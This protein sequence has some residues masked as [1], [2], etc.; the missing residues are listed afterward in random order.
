MFLDYG[1]YVPIYVSHAFVHLYPW[2]LCDPPCEKVPPPPPPP[3]RL[4]YNTFRRYLKVNFN[5]YITQ[6][7]LFKKK[8]N[9][10]SKFLSVDDTKRT[11]LLNKLN[12]LHLKNSTPLPFS[13]VSSSND[14]GSDKAKAV[15]SATVSMAVAPGTLAVAA[16]AE[17]TVIAEVAV[18][19]AAVA[20]VTV[21]AVAA[22]ATLAAVAAA[23]ATL[24]AAA[25]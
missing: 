17:A 8:C 3:R 21:A 13:R 6:F 10:F 22:A 24:A 19:V 1:I 16:V 14:D 12:T 15:S 20:A 18:N 7:E 4:C 23:A 9:Y 2:P 11:R 25:T 5:D